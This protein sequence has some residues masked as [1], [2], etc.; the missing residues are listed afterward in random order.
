MKKLISLGLLSLMST[1]FL[2]A[3]A[4][5]NEIKITQTGDTLDLYI[6]LKLDSVIR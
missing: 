4:R 6:D 5:N 3:Q 2:F 1:T